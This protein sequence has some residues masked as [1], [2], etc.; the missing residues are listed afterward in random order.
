MLSIDIPALEIFIEETNEFISTQPVTLQMEHSLISLSKWEQKWHK[1]FMS[2]LKE[3]EKTNEQLL[4]YIRCMTLTKNVDDNVF[5]YMPAECIAKINE[6]I[7]DPMTA[8]WFN[9]PKDEKPSREIMTSELL[10]YYMIKLGIPVEFQKWH[11][12]RLQ[13]LIEV[14]AVKDAP[15]EKLSK[16]EIAKRRTALNNARLAKYNTRG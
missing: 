12:N 4:D 7:D 9:R 10:Y 16:A 5:L 14:F 11:L 8:T 3:H 13:T 2:K 15:P 6:Y 1:P